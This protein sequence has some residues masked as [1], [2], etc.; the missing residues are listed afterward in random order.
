MSRNKQACKQKFIFLDR[1][2]HNAKT[3]PWGLAKK[4]ARGRGGGGGATKDVLRNR[5]IEVLK[6]SQY[7][8]IP[9][10]S[11]DLIAFNNTL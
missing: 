4:R 3:Q 7:L 1:L 6:K 8:S 11:Q 10:R 5:K 2:K 9:R